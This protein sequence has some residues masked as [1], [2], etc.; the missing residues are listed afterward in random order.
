VIAFVALAACSKGGNPTVATPP[1]G[2]VAPSN[3]P[4]AGQS[5]VVTSPAFATNTNIPRRYT[6]QGQRISPPLR[7]TNIPSGASE[8]ALVL[9]DPDA[10][11]GG[12]VH[13]VVFKIPTSVHGFDEGSVPLGVRQA[14]NGAGKASYLGPCPPMG[15]VHHYQF[16]LSALRS[17]FSLPNG[18]PAVD[19]RAEIASRS[20]ADGVLVGLY[21]RL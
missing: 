12:F 5:I 13:W 21:Q 14:S 16:T 10:P 8:L 2:S 20:I 1:A 3:L 11:N 17:P 7:W 9:F 6:C 4:G 19:V 15:P 18:A